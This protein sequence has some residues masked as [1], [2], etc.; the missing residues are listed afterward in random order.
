[1]VLGAQPDAVAGGDSGMCMRVCL[2]RRT[3]AYLPLSLFLSRDALQ[4]AKVL[5][6]MCCL[7]A[8]LLHSDGVRWRLI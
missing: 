8:G 7:L 6:T 4:S 5:L 2:C 3:L 1:M